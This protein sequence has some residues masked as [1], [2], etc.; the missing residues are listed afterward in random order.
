MGIS[1]VRRSEYPS[2]S[3]PTNNHN[4]L[5]VHVRSVLPYITRF[6]KQWTSHM[7]IDQVFLPRL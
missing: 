2:L 4:V 3:D 1:K 5:V 7:N 6:L